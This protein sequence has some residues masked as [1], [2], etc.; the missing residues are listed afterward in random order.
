MF[1]GLET[2]SVLH[3]LHHYTPLA[4]LDPL[5]V[6]E[7][8]K[9]RPRVPSLSMSI[10]PPPQFSRGPTP[11]KPPHKTVA[12]SP[13]TSALQTQQQK[14]PHRAKLKPEQERDIAIFRSFH[15]LKLVLDALWAAVQINSGI[16]PTLPD[17]ERRSEK[18]EDEAEEE[19]EEEK[20]VNVIQS[21][22]KPRTPAVRK[23]D[24]GKGED[25]TK[26]EISGGVK[27][28]DYIDQG[29]PG[30]NTSLRD[31]IYSKLVL[32]K[33]QEAKTYI[34]LLYPLNYRLEILENIFSLLFL[35][36]ED[37]VLH[38]QEESGE[39]TFNHGSNHSS[40]MEG[41]AHQL[42]SFQSDGEYSA[43]LSSVTLLRSKHGFLV[44]EK[45]T[46][47][48]LSVLQD[49]M[50][51]LS[52]ARYALSQPTMTETTPTLQPGDIK[53]SVSASLAQQ[54]SAKLEQYI[55]EARW[56]LQLV[57]SQRGTQSDKNHSVGSLRAIEF[58][59]S[60]DSGSEVS[61]S[62]TEP[63]EKPTEGKRR[64][65]KLRRIS[66][67]PRES[68]SPVTQPTPEYEMTSVISNR[69]PPTIM[70]RLTY[71]EKIAV[72]V[73][74]ESS[75]RASPSKFSNSQTFPSLSSHQLSPSPKLGKRHNVRQRSPRVSVEGHNERKDPRHS[76]RPS[77]SSSLRTSDPP[78]PLLCE[79]D[80]GDC[81]DVEEKSPQHRK[82]KRRLQNRSLQAA[83]KRRLKIS[84]RTGAL[85]GAVGQM[86]ASPTSLLRMCLKHSNYSRAYEVLR[87]FEMEGQFGEAFVLFS[88]KFESVSRELAQQ[89]CSTTPKHSPSLTPQ[90]PSRLSRRS[91]VPTSSSSLH[92]NAH[93]HIAIANATNSTSVLESLHHLLAPTSLHRMLLSGDSHLER[94]T[95]DSTALQILTEHVPTLVMLDI[96]CS[97]RVSG[98]MVK[99]I[100]EEAS[101]QCQP[102]LESLTVKS[103]SGV[104]RSTKTSAHQD[105]SLPGPFSLLLL[106]SEVS[107][108]FTG[109]LPALH[110]RPHPPPSPPY[111]SPHAL[112]SFFPRQ[113]KTASIVSYKSFQDLYHN[114]RDRLSKLLEQDTAGVKGDI[115]AALTQSD[116]PLE[117]PHRSLSHA[118]HQRNILNSLFGEL[119]QVLAG[120]AQTVALPGSPKDRGLMRRTSSS[121]AVL[122]PDET[123]LE[124]GG[125][126]TNFV[127]Q[128]SHYLSQLVDL[129]LKCLSPA[130]TGTC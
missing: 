1:K 44:N 58:S 64:Q 23:L 62:D 85:G 61:E 126:N 78:Q 117:E 40:N 16:Y 110:V 83:K 53:S 30:L 63:E 15:A 101:S 109:S 76:P 79:L 57:S 9:H 67:D 65:K 20:G 130:P 73:P 89:S 18:E 91:P 48:L 100:V 123:S 43:A 86:L 32:D 52:A 87:M 82:R 17:K 66:T 28:E 95:H 97:S 125:V 34:S 68:K 7:I 2:H 25:V 31:Q 59:S 121:V 105:M 13:A 99:R 120:N 108:Y 55:N 33:L 21:G 36:N 107:G 6:V 93:L 77:S 22:A 26:G 5:E 124:G 71:S 54:R 104:R 80:S 50:R 42:P 92:P 10:T 69:P 122:N 116:L 129:L 113:L 3:I 75:S 45:V 49:S 4:G 24:F 14:Q 90:E 60:G 70:S 12:P 128:F 103:H 29:L 56:R 74:V 96:V 106:L 11:L 127:L 115:I 94:A 119:T 8:L 47:D 84:E 111:H 51:E 27:A 37:I 112:L 88:E 41:L 72:S 35:T 118:L 114:A 39:G 46:G 102:V 81:A 19:E 98:Q 38:Q